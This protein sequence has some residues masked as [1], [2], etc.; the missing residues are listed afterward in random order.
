MSRKFVTVVLL[1]LTLSALGQTK[2]TSEEAYQQLLKLKAEGEGLKSL[3]SY[4]FFNYYFESLELLSIVT[5][6]PDFVLTTY[7]NN[8]FFFRYHEMPKESVKNYNLFFK[9]YELNKNE[10][11][12]D[13]KKELLKKLSAAHGFMASE[14]ANLE[15]LDSAKIQHE[16][17]IEFTKQRKK[18]IYYAGALNN[19]GL[20]YYWNKKEKDSALPYFI[21]SLKLVK[22]YSPNHHLEGSVKDN[23]ADIY[24]E[25]GMIEEANKLY[26]QNFEFYRQGFVDNIIDTK[27]L[28]SA[29]CQLIKT[30]LLLKKKNAFIHFK[31]LKEI[32]NDPIYKIKNSKSKI[33]FLKTQ[34]LMYRYE[35][36]IDLAYKTSMQIASLSDSLVSVSNTNR[37]RRRGIINDIAISRMRSNYQLEKQHREDK[38]AQQKLRIWILII[39]FVSFVG[40]MTSLFL[41]R[42]QRIENAKGKQQIAEQELKLTELENEKLQSDIKSKERDL[43]DFAINLTQ[44]QEWAKVLFNKFD[45]LKGTKGRERKK[46]LENFEQE[47]KNKITFD[48]DTKEFY[49][50]LDKLS[51]AFYSQL[52]SQFPNLTKTEKRLCSLIRLKIESYEIATL[53]NITLSSLNTSRYRLRKKLKLS[54]EADLD[55]FIQCL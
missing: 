25:Q 11:S 33:E 38:I 1:L 35:Q 39:V 28:M 12:P 16:L 42:K 13:L 27:R 19:Y 45:D 2:P 14:Y 10:F 17:N 15:L 40:F 50:R 5:H 32:Y 7:Y 41:R 9:F 47:I 29:G 4:D 51:D 23:I 49:Q 48:G 52:N 8:A 46:L 6:N 55:A 20:F 31:E 36:R 22:L 53:Q 26:K 44:N 43:S 24:V 34:E 37:N 54:K 3:Q 21:K 18:S 30:D